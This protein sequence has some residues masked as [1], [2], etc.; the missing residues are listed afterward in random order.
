MTGLAKMPAD[1]IVPMAFRM[2]AGDIT[3]RRLLAKQAH[4]KP[5]N[6]Q[7]AIGVAVDEPLITL[8]SANIRR[9]YF[10]PKP[11]THALW[12]QQNVQK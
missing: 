10:S 2:A 5:K 12:K 8:D 1:E 4:F 11:W 6:C 7:S 9:Y 3:I